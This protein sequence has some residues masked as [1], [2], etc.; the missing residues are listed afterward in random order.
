MKAWFSRVW[1]DEDAFAA[2]M[3]RCY[4][5]ALVAGGLMLPKFID[6]PTLWWLAPLAA[7]AGVSIPSKPIAPKA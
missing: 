2:L 3:R 7:A 6:S 4:S 1:N 5:F